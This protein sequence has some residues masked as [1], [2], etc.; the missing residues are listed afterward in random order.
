MKMTILFVISCFA[1]A[2]VLQAPDLRH[3][4]GC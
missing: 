3:A 4:N 1:F 2:V